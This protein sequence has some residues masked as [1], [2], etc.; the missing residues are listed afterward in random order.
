MGIGSLAS[1]DTSDFNTYGP[2]HLKSPDWTNP[3]YQTGVLSSLVN[4]VYTLERDRRL[5]QKKRYRLGLRKCPEPQANPWWDFFDFELMKRLNDDDGSIYGAVFEYKNYSVY[6]NNPHVKVPQYVMA[7][8]GTVLNSKTLICDFTLVIQCMLNTLHRGGRPKHAFE[9]IRGMVDKHSDSVIWLAGHSS[10][11]A[12][13]LIAG[14]TMTRSGCFLESH[15]F[16]P[17]F[18]SIPIEQI[19]GGSLFKHVFQTAKSVVKSTIGA[20]VNLPQNQEDKSKVA[21]WIPHLYVNPNDSICSGIMHYFKRRSVM[22]KFGADGI[23][24][25]AA[26][27]S[28][29]SELVG[30]FKGSSPSDLSKEPLY[31]LPS[32]D[33][34]VNNSKPTKSTPAHAL[35]QWWER[36]PAVR[37]NWES[38]CIRSYRLKQSTL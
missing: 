28:Y 32:A 8:R 5:R 12:L 35:H 13:A 1:S 23:E 38:C 20:I 7:F 16:N 9:E 22:S 37:E 4:G 15:I 36:D 10:G 3:H 17:P 27:I 25:M 14:K 2:S 18:S 34:T 33:M 29:A 30:K 26:S 21:S 19:P 24:K 11:A 6:Q 31:V